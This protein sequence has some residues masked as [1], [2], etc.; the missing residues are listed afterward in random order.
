MASSPIR[1]YWDSDLFL[2]T[3]NRGSNPSL[4]AT[5]DAIWVEATAGK[6]QLV[7]STLSMAEVSFTRADL[8]GVPAFDREADIDAVWDAFP[9]LLLVEYSREVRASVRGTGGHA[10][11]R[12]HFS[13]A[14]AIR[15]PGRTGLRPCA[16]RP[17]GPPRAP[18]RGSRHR[19]SRC[20]GDRRRSDPPP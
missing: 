12:W 20:P 13:A 14:V 3:L 11:L 1:V 2:R 8:E 16:P 17:S 15:G 19:S 4:L 7:T 10:R 5:L 9:A 18:R 6:I